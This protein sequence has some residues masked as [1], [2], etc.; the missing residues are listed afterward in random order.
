MHCVLISCV[1]I[2]TA[3]AS[4]RG[5]GEFCRVCYESDRQRCSPHGLRQQTTERCTL[6]NRTDKVRKGEDIFGVH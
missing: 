3:A 1:M 2:L 4:D 6:T 5:S